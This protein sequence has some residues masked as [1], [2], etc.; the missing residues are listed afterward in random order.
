VT[1]KA[2]ERFES[3]RLVFRRPV[4]DDDRSILERYAGDAEVT[5]YLGWP[6]HTSIAD[7]RAF[8]AVSDAEWSRWPAGPYLLFSRDGGE[9][10]GGT[11][12]VFETPERAATG[13]V[14][15]RDA[16]GRGYA[17]EALQAMVDLARTVQIRHLYALCHPDHQASAR[18][19]IKCGFQLEGIRPQSSKSSEFPNLHPGQLAD[20]H[21]YATT[22]VSGPP[23]V[24]S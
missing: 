24:R 14:L 23:P 6:R 20:V 19:L 15:A 18:V 9:L 3:T 21:C 11:G 2:A 5:R 10:L 16:W 12:L 4:V 17:S 13:Y 1:P 8:L 22:L 7:T